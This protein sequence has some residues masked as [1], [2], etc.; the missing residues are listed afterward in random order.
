MGAEVAGVL[1]AI[2]GIGGLGVG[3]R[4]CVYSHG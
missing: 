2:S 4:V 3:Q 1:G